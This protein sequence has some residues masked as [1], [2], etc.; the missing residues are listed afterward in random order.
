MNVHSATCSCS[1]EIYK[2]QFTLADFFPKLGYFAGFWAAMMVGDNI[3]FRV[4]NTLQ[5]CDGWGE[6]RG[7]L[8]I[9]ASLVQWKDIRLWQPEFGPEEN[10][11]VSG[12]FAGFFLYISSE[13]SA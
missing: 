6:G 4:P 3:F 9:K 11:S 1:F 2:Q 5:G 7:I 12:N 10:H 8:Y 13:G